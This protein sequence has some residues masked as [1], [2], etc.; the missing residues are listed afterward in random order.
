MD[1]ISTRYG[2]GRLV[3]FLLMGYCLGGQL[4]EDYLVQFVVDRQMLFN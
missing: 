1:A 4:M 3:T 2:V